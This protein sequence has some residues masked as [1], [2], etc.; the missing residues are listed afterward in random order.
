MAT[1]LVIGHQKQSIGEIALQ[2]P[3][4]REPELP[5]DRGIAAHAY[6]CRIE[7]VRNAVD[8][9]AKALLCQGHIH[10]VIVLVDEI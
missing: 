3:V 1:Y 9:K 7:P 10:V 5:L 4:F 2:S 6:D 8:H